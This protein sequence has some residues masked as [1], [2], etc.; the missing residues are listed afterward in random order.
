MVTGLDFNLMGEVVATIDYY[1][2]CVISDINT[3]NY[4]SHMNMEMKK[5]RGG[6]IS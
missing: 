1:G 3:N 6:I 2:A 5:D 4:R